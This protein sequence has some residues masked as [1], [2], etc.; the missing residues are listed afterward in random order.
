M[1]DVQLIASTIQTA[2]DAGNNVQVIT[3]STSGVTG[4]ESTIGLSK[5]ERQAAGKP[6]LIFQAHERFRDKS[7]TIRQIHLAIG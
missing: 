4:P 7:L 3:H 6:E 1:P 5:A 2:S